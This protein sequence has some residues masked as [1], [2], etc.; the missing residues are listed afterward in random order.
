MVDYP[1]Y[2]LWE[3]L[4]LLLHRLLDLQ[5]KDYRITPSS[6]A[7]TPRSSRNNSPAPVIK[8]SVAEDPLYGSELVMKSLQA[9]QF[10][11]Y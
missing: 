11:Y 5:A 7:V 2:S 9:G 3:T 4:C 10:S 6:Q 1:L 8:Q